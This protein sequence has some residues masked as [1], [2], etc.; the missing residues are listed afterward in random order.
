MKHAWQSCRNC[1]C[2]G[3]CLPSGFAF[4][5]SDTYGCHVH[6]IDLSVNMIL[7]AIERA[8]AAVRRSSYYNND[9]PPAAAATAAMDANSNGLHANGNGGSGAGSPTG[10]AGYQQ[11][12]HDVTLE[13]ADVLT[14]DFSDATFDVVMCKDSLLHVEGKQELFSR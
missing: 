3:R 12:P 2:A 8:A 13:V 9:V 14:R 4:L 1:C 6:G 10:R 7:T 5:A 11:A